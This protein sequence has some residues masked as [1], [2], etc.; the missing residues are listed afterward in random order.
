[1]FVNPIAQVAWRLVYFKAGQEVGEGV[2][3]ESEAA[4]AP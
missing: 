3:S 2:A 1:L 4:F